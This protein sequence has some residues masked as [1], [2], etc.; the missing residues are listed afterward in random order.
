[1]TVAAGTA[2]TLEFDNEDASVPHDV[3]IQDGNGAE[4]FTTDIFPGVDTRSFEVPALAAGTYPFVCTV[5]S[6]M[7]GTLTVQ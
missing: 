3:Q 2:F 1:V 7:T 4:V 5:H 6:N